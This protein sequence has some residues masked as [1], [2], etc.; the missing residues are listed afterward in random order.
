MLDQT[1]DREGAAASDDDVALDQHRIHRDEDGVH[2]M[3]TAPSEEAMEDGS[4]IDDVT[5][6]YEDSKT[7]VSSE[8]AFQ[9][10][11]AKYVSKQGSKVA[12]FG[13]G[14]A[15]LANVALI[16]LAIGAI[17][18]LATLIGPLAATLIVVAVLLVGAGVLGYMAKS[19][20]SEISRV[21]SGGRA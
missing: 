8:V 9:K 3:A 6:L 14:A 16:A 5:A 18:A 11:R 15:V 1:Q 20:V 19:K 13:V 12:I 17:L 21:M 2:A 10:T 7:Y 4:L